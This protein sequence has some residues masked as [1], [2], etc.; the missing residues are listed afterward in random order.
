MTNG[1]KV[2]INLKNIRLI[3][4]RNNA[5]LTQY[6]L[7]KETGLSQSMIAHVEAGRKDPSTKYKIALAK[8]LEVTVEW[9][10]YEQFYDLMS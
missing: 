8:Y 10:F 9:L 3:E 2:V 5:G 1:H 7:A 6:E 4:L